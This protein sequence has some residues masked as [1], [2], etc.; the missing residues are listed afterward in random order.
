MGENNEKPGEYIV[1]FVNQNLKGEQRSIREENIRITDFAATPED[2]L[3]K[4]IVRIEREFSCP[5]EYSY[6]ETS[7]GKEKEVLVERLLLKTFKKSSEYSK[8]FGWRDELCCNSKRYLHRDSEKLSKITF[9]IVFDFLG[10]SGLSNHKIGWQ[11]RNICSF[12]V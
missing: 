3:N 2:F 4:R 9:T 12:Q 7:C 6:N 10:P 11:N 1:K 5:D 8:F